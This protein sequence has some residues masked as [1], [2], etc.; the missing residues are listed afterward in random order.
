[1]AVKKKRKAIKVGET[2]ECNVKCTFC[3]G[4]CPHRVDNRIINNF[5]MDFCTEHSHV[6]KYTKE[7]EV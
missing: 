3:K 6:F 4:K 7:S 1:M 5:V 2:V